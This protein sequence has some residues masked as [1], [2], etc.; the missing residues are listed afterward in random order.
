MKKLITVTLILA[1]LLPGLALAAG[2]SG[3]WVSYE[4][5]NTGAPCV[6]FLYL[7]DNGTCF[8]LVQLFNQDDA[9]FGRTFVGTWEQQPDGSVIAKTGNN[10]DTRL[11]FQSEGIAIDSDLS[12]WV[13]ITQFTL[14]GG[15]PW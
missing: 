3:C 15:S 12:V 4:L 1:L 13:N 7:A 5:L 14:K 9:G 11:R 10:T 6:S 8:Y 2:V